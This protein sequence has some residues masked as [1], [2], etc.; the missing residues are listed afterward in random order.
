MFFFHVS[1]GPNLSFKGHGVHVVLYSRSYLPSPSPFQDEAQAQAQSLESELEELR[2]SHRETRQRL[3]TSQQQLTTLQT[4]KRFLDNQ[5]T[6]ARSQAGAQ[7]RVMSR[8]VGW[9][10]GGC[11]DDM[12]V[13]E[14]G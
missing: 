6:E 9:E 5:L 13:L 8:G 4:E 11:C 14:S 3:D 12:R 7:V 1:H 10:S 2:T